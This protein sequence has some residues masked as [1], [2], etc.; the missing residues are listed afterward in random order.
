M[1]TLLFQNLISIIGNVM[2]GT[3][4]EYLLNEGMK[5]KETLG[6]IWKDVY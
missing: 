6:E 3:L 2:Q 1:Q 5:N 4:L